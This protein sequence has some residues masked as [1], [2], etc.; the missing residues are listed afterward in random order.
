MPMPKMFYLVPPGTRYDFIGKRNFWLSLSA[1]VIG[2]CIVSMIVQGFNYGVD[3]AGG[4]D[5]QVNFGKA[6]LVEAGEIRAAMRAAAYENAEVSTFGDSPNSFLIRLPQISYL[7]DAKVEELKRALEAKF[8][9][10]NPD[11]TLQPLFRKEG[12]FL[13]EGGRV[14][15]GL[16]KA[17]P[18]EEIAK[19]F[20]EQ[21]IPLRRGVEETDSET[22]E[23]VVRFRLGDMTKEQFQKAR[24]D[25]RA[26]LGAA[27]VFEDLELRR[28]RA[29]L[30]FSQAMSTSQIE[31]VLEE[32]KFEVADP[33]EVLRK[34]RNE[35]IVHMVGLSAKIAEDLRR[36]FPKNKVF[37][38]R[39]DSV[40]PK[41]G[42]QLREDAIVSLLYAIIGILI[43]TAFRF[44]FIF[45]PGAVVALIHD[46]L[47]TVGYFSLFQVEFTLGTVAAVL[48]IIGYSVNDTIVIYDRCREN[49][50][51]YREWKLA[52]ILNLSMNEMLGRTLLTSMLT[53]FTVLSMLIL[54]GGLIQDFALALLVG[55]ISGVYSTIFIAAP[56]TLYME[57]IV[58]RVK[59]RRAL[60]A[61]ER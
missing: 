17:V 19:V 46:A 49:I 42:A 12:G 13:L 11:G 39:V 43:Y 1:L 58:E 53:I 14:E 44:D 41:V 20:L 30:R 7:S 10:K 57:K 40:G 47:F 52:D 37:V 55:M 38:E 50:A 61:A 34:E 22:H 18:P 5:V 31:K 28:D 48:T 35:Y 16:T 29:T 24:E 27:L 33:V 25:V 3:F 32:A 4:T 45:A 2:T 56:F 15:L 23:Y 26:K 8:A 54:G 60:L 6:P 59:A 9:D 51:K 21:K 36:A